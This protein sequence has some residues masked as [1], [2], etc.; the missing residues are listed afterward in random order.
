MKTIQLL[1][2]AKSDWTDATL[3]DI[4]RPLNAR[5]MRSTKLMATKLVE[6]NC[7]FDTIYCSPAVRAQSTIQ[8]IS[9]QLPDNNIKWNT[10]ENLYTFDA[11]ELF[12]WFQKLDNAIS[13]VLIVGHNPALTDFCHALTD[14][15]IQNIPTCAYVRLNAMHECTW[16]QIAQTPFTLTNFIKPKDF[17]ET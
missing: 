10:D 11:A 14:S 8:R 1:R 12:A 2:H 9:E 3:A 17:A 15:N 13:S 16:S 5:G 7:Q 6:V 4:Q